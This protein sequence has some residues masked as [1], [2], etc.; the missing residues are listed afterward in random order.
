[1]EKHR[2]FAAGLQLQSPWYIKEVYLNEDEGKKGVLHIH[3]DHE[4]RV[5]FEYENKLYS[6]YDHQERTWQ[7]LNFFQYK[8]I[9][10]ARVPRIKNAKGE[11]KLVEVP[12]AQKG[13]SFSLLFEYDVLELIELGMSASDV[14]RRYQLY[15]KTVFRI[16]RKYVSHAL[17]TQEIDIVKELAIDETSR[18]KGHNYLTVLTDRKEKK[19]VGLAAGK[20]K[21][22]VAHSLIDMEVRG[23]DRTKVQCI[24]MDM[25]PAYISSAEELMP[26]AKVV[27][28]RFHI[29]KKMNEAVD[30]IRREDQ[31]EY[32]ELKKSRYLWLK[33]RSK[34]TKEQISNVDHLCE[35]CQNIG[36]AYQLKELLRL[37]MDNAYTEKKVTPLN[38]WMKLAWDS[39]LMPIR[40]FVNM[41]RRHWYGVKEYFY[42][43][44]TNAYA[45][46][47]NLK[48]QEIKRLA[49]GY[50]NINNFIVMIYFHLGGLTFKPTK[51]D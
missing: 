38:E 22:A 41:L 10:H 14:G 43:L 5:K 8:C 17:S 42:R 48:I 36:K 21:E 44:S 13:S 34:L 27:F 49:R 31:K 39:G 24:T 9:I 26:E 12:W 40:K 28:D 2:L 35:L 47:V 6:V 3:I 46:R 4:S 33:N 51:F 50:R 23:G 16:V 45:E 19:V 29:V 11:V 18:K 25:S 30:Q 1:M 32:K 7:H 20:D 37:V 15:G